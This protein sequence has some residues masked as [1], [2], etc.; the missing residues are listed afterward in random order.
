MHDVFKRKFLGEKIIGNTAPVH[1]E[2]DVFAQ[3]DARAVN[4]LRI[5]VVRIIKAVARNR[6]AV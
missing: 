4:V 1:R 2:R 6:A 5:I 3:S